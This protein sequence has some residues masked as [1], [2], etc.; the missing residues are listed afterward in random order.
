MPRNRRPHEALN[1][2]DMSSRAARR[3]SAR[4]ERKGRRISPTIEAYSAVQGVQG[5]DRAARGLISRANVRWENLRKFL[6][7]TTQLCL[8]SLGPLI[9]IDL[10]LHEAGASLTKSPSDPSGD[11]PSQLQWGADSSASALRLLLL[12]Q[13]VGAAAIARQQLERWTSNLASTQGIEQADGEP[14]EDFLSRVWAPYPELPADPAEA[15]MSLSELLH[16]RQADL[17]LVVESEA[18]NLAQTMT[19]PVA[20]GLR[21]VASY[22]ELPLLQVLGCVTTLA[23]EQGLRAASVLGQQRFPRRV[24]GKDTWILP[25]LWPYTPLNLSTPSLV[26]ASSRVANLVSSARQQGGEDLESALL[27]SSFVERRL[28]AAAWARKAN[29]LEEEALGV[30]YNA[31]SVSNNEE[32]IVKVAEMAALIA[33]WLGKESPASQALMVAASALRSALL[34]WLED[35]DRSMSATRTALECVA[36]VRAWRLKPSLADRLTER[37]MVSTPRDWY[38]AAGWRRL[39]ILTRSLAELSHFRP[40]IRWSGARG[41]LAQTVADDLTKGTDPLLRARGRTL[42]RTVLLLA[43]EVIEHLRALDA[44]LADSYEVLISRTAG[45]PPGGDLEEWLNRL[46]ELRDADLGEADF[47]YPDDD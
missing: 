45:E 25:L 24:K 32:L 15:Y 44:G 8:P 30:D 5:A 47:V 37:G 14:L 41:A 31:L 42:R 18:L 12:R 11:W 33:T 40:G 38:E 13:P 43:A 23:E 17:L 2:E 19:E 3:E 28:R 46:W 4:L 9:A 6:P 1:I 7:E 35:D 16:G 29:A 34:L 22:V 27:M 20:Q 26:N 10:G 36:R 39:S 21:R